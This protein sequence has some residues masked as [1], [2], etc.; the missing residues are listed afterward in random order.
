MDASDLINIKKAKAQWVYYS[1]ATS[2]INTGCQ[3]NVCANVL[4]PPCKVRY[5]TYE[6][7]ENIRVGRAECNPECSTITCYYKSTA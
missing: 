2:T 7:R 1:A 4:Q 5:D 3:N 6:N